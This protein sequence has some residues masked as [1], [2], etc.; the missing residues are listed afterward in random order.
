MWFSES[1]SSKI[2]VCLKLLSVCLYRCI[3][4]ASVSTRICTGYFHTEIQLIRGGG[5][6]LA[7]LGV[8]VKPGSRKVS[9][10]KRGSHRMLSQEGGAPNLA[11]WESFVVVLWA[12][13]HL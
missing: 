6:S 3:S 5:C 12:I 4:H 13:Q 10:E 1:W 7:G 11:L 2:N 9:Q 8:V